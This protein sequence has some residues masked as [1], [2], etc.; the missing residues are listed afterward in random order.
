MK[1]G[2][3]T[4][5][6]LLLLLA[7]FARAA[8]SPE[9]HAS[10]ERRVQARLDQWG[11]KIDDLRSHSQKAGASARASVDEALKELDSDLAAARKQLGPLHS[12]SGSA[13]DKLRAG[14][15]QATE[16]LRREYARAKRLFETSDKSPSKRK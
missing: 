7:P 8:Q 5:A 2:G 14:A 16:K 15:D 12:S 9:R 4:G 3:L 1:N 11:A 6:V 13:W 10:Y